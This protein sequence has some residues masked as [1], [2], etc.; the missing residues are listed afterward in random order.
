LSYSPRTV[1]RGIAPR[2]E[3]PKPSVLLL[4]QRTR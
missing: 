3:G 4:H 1:R 2:A